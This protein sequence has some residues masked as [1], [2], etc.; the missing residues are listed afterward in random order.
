MRKLKLQMQLSVDGYVAGPTGELDWMTWNWDDELNKY[1]SD[2][3]SNVDLLLLGRK[4]AEGFIPYWTAAYENPEGPEPG[5]DQMVNTQKLVFT[6]TLQNHNWKNTGLA[7]GFL[8]EE[9][10]ALK[11]TEGKDLITYGGASFASSLIAGQLIDDYYF[12]INP[13]VL[14]SGLTI[15]KDIQQ[16]LTLK[17]VESRAFECGIMALHYQPA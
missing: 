13:V 2:L 3:S 16:R 8:N 6:H 15:F 12:F 9:I 7:R 5:S 1:V 14:G 17:L 10:S 11:K 4:L